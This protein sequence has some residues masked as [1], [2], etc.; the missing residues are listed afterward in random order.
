MAQ[1][2]ECARVVA[3]LHNL[4][5]SDALVHF[6]HGAGEHPRVIAQQRLLLAFVQYDSLHLCDMLEKR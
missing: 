2:E 3:H 6:G 4:A 1:G 5:V